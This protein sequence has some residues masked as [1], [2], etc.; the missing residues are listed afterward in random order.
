MKYG[1]LALALAA[2]SSSAT[3]EP[4]MKAKLGPLQLKEFDAALGEWRTIAVDTSRVFAGWNWRNQAWGGS[5]DDLQVIIPISGRPDL[6]IREPLVVKVTPRRKPRAIQTREFSGVKLSPQGTSF[7]LIQ[8]K[9]VACA[10]PF[11]V[12]AVLGE[13]KA[14]LVLGLE[15]GE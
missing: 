3:A 15:C 11:D 10:G 2:F 7:Q 1:T 6:A 12:E 4:A 5:D 8:L 9:D 14:T 13:Q